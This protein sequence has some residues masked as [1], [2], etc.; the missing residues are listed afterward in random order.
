MVLPTNSYF[1]TP[2]KI[3]DR[4][5]AN[6]FTSHTDPPPQLNVLIYPFSKQIE[7]FRSRL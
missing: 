5:P 2:N 1:P 6:R 3:I 7:M 4:E